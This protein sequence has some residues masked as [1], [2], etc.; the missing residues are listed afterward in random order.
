[1][2]TT[3]PNFGW[4]VPTSSDLVKN[5]AT[6]IETLGDAVD[7]SIAGLTVNAQTG[8]TYTAVKADGLNS[9]VTMDNAA[10]NIFSI[11]TDATY[12]FPIGTTLVVYQ[13]GAGITTIQ[14]V[15]SGT[16]T[17]VSAGLVAAAPVL[18]RYKSAAAIKL[19][20]NSWTVVGGIA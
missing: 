9:I 12:D 1:M 18:A 11:P 19:A 15:T 7:A 3:T 17:V 2:A 14:A 6:A 8:L 13:K 20:A 4:T 5:G 16:T 10:A